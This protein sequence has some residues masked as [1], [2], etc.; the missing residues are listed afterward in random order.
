MSLN[1][2]IIMGNLTRNPEIRY[3]PQG[4]AVCDLGL[5]INEKYKNGAGEAVEETCFIDVTVWGRQAETFAEYLKKGSRALVSGSLKLDTWEKDGQKRNRIRVRASNVQFIDRAEGG[6]PS[7]PNGNHF[8]E[9]N[10]VQF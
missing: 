4:K 2:V 5:A 10:D 9:S 3:T 1:A 6:A 7:E 8:D